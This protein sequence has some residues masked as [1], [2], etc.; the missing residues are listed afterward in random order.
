V[1]LYLNSSQ[2]GMIN[3]PFNENLAPIAPLFIY[4]R[5]ARCDSLHSYPQQLSSVKGA[6]RGQPSP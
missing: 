5:S 1:A 6:C 3:V 2:G 4:M